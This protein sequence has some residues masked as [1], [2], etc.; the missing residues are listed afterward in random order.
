VANFTSVL[1]I[2]YDVDTSLTADQRQSLVELVLKVVHENKTSLTVDQQQSL[3]QLVLKNV[4][5][6]T[7]NQQQSLVELVLKI[8]YDI[9]TSVQRRSLIEQVLKM[10]YDPTNTKLSLNQRQSL[11]EQ[12]LAPTSGLLHDEKLLVSRQ[13]CHVQQPAYPVYP[14]ACGS[15]P[16]LFDPAVS[17]TPD[18]LT[19]AHAHE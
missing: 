10:V 3:V 8:V 13:A 9:E 18:V 2:V 1:D 5:D 11:V 6:S 4:S 17:F 15:G 19:H 16:H 7:F 14:A 12:L